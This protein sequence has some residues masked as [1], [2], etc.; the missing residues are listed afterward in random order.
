MKYNTP[1]ETVTVLGIDLAKNSFH[2]YG[3][4]ENENTVLSKKLTRAKLTPS[5]HRCRFV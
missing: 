2:L 4:N 3:I 1:K 5:L